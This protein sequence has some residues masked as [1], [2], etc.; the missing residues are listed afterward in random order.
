MP[1]APWRTVLETATSRV[2]G[3]LTRAE[4]RQTAAAFAEGLAVHIGTQ[5]LLVCRRAGR[6]GRSTAD[7]TL[8]RTAVWDAY[9]ISW[10]TKAG[11]FLQVETDAAARTCGAS[12]HTAYNTRCPQRGGMTVDQRPFLRLQRVGPGPWP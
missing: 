12:G 1:P 7:A 2:A 3:R 6:A 10:L 8:L 9:A 5:N 11:Q 4:P